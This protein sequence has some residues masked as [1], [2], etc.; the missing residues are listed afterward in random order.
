M[1][2]A[3][4]TNVPMFSGRA[5]P[6]GGCAYPQ[7]NHSTAAIPRISAVTARSLGVAPAFVRVAVSVLIPVPFASVIPALQRKVAYF[8][9]QS[10]PGSQR[11]G[12]LRAGQ[13]VRSS[14]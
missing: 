6:D 14:P 2:T 9:L 8:A 5:H 7:P 11:P 12:Q 10:Q 1:A 13:R 4:A 3:I